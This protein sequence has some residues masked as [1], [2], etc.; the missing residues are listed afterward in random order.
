MNTWSLVYC[1]IRK[2]YKSSVFGVVIVALTILPVIALFKFSA[3][4]VNWNMYFADTLEFFT[5]FL[6]LGFSFTACWSFGQE[7]MDKTIND[8][9]V[10]PVSKLRIAIAKFILIF[11]WNILMAILM[12]IVVLLIGAYM[13]LAGGTATLILHYFFVFM[14]VS[15]LS[16]IVSTVTSFLAV[17]TRGYLAPIGFIFLLIV[18]IS[19]IGD[20]GF[21]AYFPWTIPGLLISNGTLS[22]ISILILAITGIIGFVGTVAWWRFA[23]QQ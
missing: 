12:F 1:E 11:L 18:I 16:T 22:P 13:G 3:A 17:I 2:V 15:L 21:Y 10:K 9:L 23:E 19:I 5:T 8:L 14:A 20:E 4:D 7:Y 6:V